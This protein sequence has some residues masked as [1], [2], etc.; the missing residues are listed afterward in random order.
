MVKNTRKR[1]FFSCGCSVNPMRINSVVKEKLSSVIS[2]LS[3]EIEIWRYK[4]L[5][6]V[7]IVFHIY[8]YIF[9]FFTKK[10]EIHGQISGLGS[11]HFPTCEAKSIPIARQE[12][13]VF[14]SQRSSLSQSSQSKFADHHPRKTKTANTLDD[15]SPQNADLACADLRVW[16]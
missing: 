15:G 6:R 16:L 13:Q 4:I 14:L 5:I 3:V 2:T 9:F 7:C 1:G 8:I 11:A 10:K 12:G